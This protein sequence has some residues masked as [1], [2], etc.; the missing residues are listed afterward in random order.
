MNQRV[1][2]PV[3][4][5]R[6]AE[7][8]SPPTVPR[9]RPEERGRN[10]SPA[11]A[12]QPAVPSRPGVKGSTYVAGLQAELEGW[13]EK[14]ISLQAQVEMQ[15]TETERLEL[16]LEEQTKDASRLQSALEARGEET[17]RL[18]DQVE[19][20]RT[21]V[22]Q[23]QAEA[24][25]RQEQALRLQA[26]MD[27]YRKRQQRLAADQTETERRRLLGDFVRVVDNLERALAAPAGDSE[28]LRQ[29][30]A[31]THRAALKLLHQEGVEL[32]QSENQPF[33]PNWHEAVAT[34]RAEDVAG[35]NGRQ[36]DPDTVIQ[37]LEP[38]YRQ[39]DRLLRPARVV[40]AV[41]R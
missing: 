40:V 32:V 16:A 1:N 17:Q 14:A 24:E 13:R 18:R 22:E 36:P 39:G 19:M 21:Q 30:V 33:D 6:P 15:R 20:Q 25:E 23:A 35:D 34:V 4:V 2:I 10:E 8:Q 26:E 31:L 9:P 12:V 28:T 38:G 11:P 3:R 7:Y 29:G 41:K 27:N 5:I 37:V